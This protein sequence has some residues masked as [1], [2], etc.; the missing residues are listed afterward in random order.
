MY[1]AKCKKCSGG[2]FWSVRRGKLKCKN[3]RYEFT[4]KLGGI[5]LS[6]AKWKQLLKW[7]LR[8]QSIN[9]VCE[10]TSIS[11]YKVLGKV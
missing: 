5:N 10:E 8:C 7:F 9:V 3:C 1:R 4:L 11:K 6:K 2:S